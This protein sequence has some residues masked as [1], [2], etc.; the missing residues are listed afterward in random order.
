[1]KTFIIAEAGV[2]HNG[3]LELAKRL[4]DAASD[5]KCDAVKFQT[6]KADKL[7]S[8]NAEKAEYQKETTGSDESQLD[9]IRK[10]ELSE[11]DH[12]VL[13][14]YCEEKGILFLSSAFD[15]ES[16]TFLESMDMPLYKIPSGE[17]TNL[18]LLRQIGSYHKRVI[19]SCG[20]C[21][22]DEIHKAYD[23]L[24]ESG[25]TEVAILHCNTQYPT[26]FEDVNLNV[27]KTLSDEFH[28][29][30]GY[31]D[32][33]VGIEVPIAAVALGAEIIEKHFTLD[34]NMEGPDHRA[35]L[36]P[37]ELKAMVDGIRHIEKALGSYEK[38]VSDSERANRDI[39]RKS[40]VAACSIK[41]GE[42]FTEANLTMKRPGN[43][44]SSSKYEDMLGKKAKHD[45]EVDAL[46]C[47]DELD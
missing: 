23:T 2:N 3:S 37:E 25:A 20:M 10:L 39:A 30:I 27:M 13:K 15:E 35:S 1:M 9:M 29:S 33:T 44:I 17:I 34:K 38:K 18:K 16:L 36:N 24:M 31:S 4:V 7:V 5:A 47:L 22:M 40:L 28:T 43:G 6:F 21:E 42:T 14:K 26:P 19:M 45:Y 11:E 41:K 46:L 8:V 12:Y 32:H